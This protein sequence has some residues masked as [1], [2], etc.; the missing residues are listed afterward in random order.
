MEEEVESSGVCG[1]SVIDGCS[2]PKWK[3]Y[4][5]RFRLMVM[6]VIKTTF[7]MSVRITLVYAVI[8]LGLLDKKKAVPP[9]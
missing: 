8:L 3:I 4:I 2:C 5:Y 6:A 1:S 9:E 7:T